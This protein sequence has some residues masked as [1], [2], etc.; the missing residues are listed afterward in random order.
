MKVDLMYKIVYTWLSSFLTCIL[1]IELLCLVCNSVVLFNF[2]VT[3]LLYN[4]VPF[5]YKLAVYNATLWT[6]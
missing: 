3:A 1:L 2:A 4:P 6:K 5:L